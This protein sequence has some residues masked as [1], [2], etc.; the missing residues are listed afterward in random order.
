MKVSH[1]RPS[2]GIIEKIYHRAM[3]ARDKNGVILIQALC[4]DIRDA[5]WSF[6]PSQGVAEF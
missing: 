4:D 2:V 1:H 3:A 6:E 5:S